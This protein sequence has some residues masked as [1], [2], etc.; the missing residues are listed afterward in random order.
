MIQKEDPKNGSTYH[1]DKWEDRLS[2]EEF[3]ITRFAS[4]F[5]GEFHV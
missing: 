4:G 2:H 5:L 1:E 3:E